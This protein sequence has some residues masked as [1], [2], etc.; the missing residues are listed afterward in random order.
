MVSASF[1]SHLCNHQL[2]LLA[3]SAVMVVAMS[4]PSFAQESGPEA[5]KFAQSSTPE[6]LRALFEK[7]V[8]P[9]QDGGQTPDLN[10]RLFR[11][12]AIDSSQKYPLVVFLHGAGE[13]GGDNEAQLV[14]SVHEFA[15]PDRQKH[16]PAFVIAPQCPKDRKW[17]EIDW[18][19][20]S[21]KGSFDEA[22]SPVIDSVMQLVETM[23]DSEPI[24]SSRIYFT[25]LSMGGYGSWYASAKWADKVAAVI[26]V[27]GGGDPA[28]AARYNGVAIWALHGQK[29]SAVPIGRSR[30]MVAAIASVGHAPEVRYTEY[31]GVNHDS[32]T[33][34]FTRDDLFAWLFAQKK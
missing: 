19:Q 18:S 34:S 3:V 27:C 6:E 13:R 15:R 11:P 31:P 25:G 1:A 21:G 10:Y 22:A 33:R 29:D 2:R 32:W 20:K 12:A 26:P 23:L 16:Y 14:H 8:F 9:S 30:E 7:K 5:R 17:V 24:D 4:K 28:W